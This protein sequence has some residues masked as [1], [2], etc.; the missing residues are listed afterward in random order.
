LKQSGYRGPLWAIIFT[1]TVE[2]IRRC[3][4]CFACEEYLDP[5][6]DLTFGEIFRAAVHDHARALTS[7]TL[8]TCDKLLLNGLHC[9][10]G[11]D[12]EAIIQ[13]LRE[14]ARLRGIDPKISH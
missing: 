14:E 8:W 4:Q 12:L 7:R 11:L 2:D 6:M 9:Q 13:A 10:S 1:A 5:G 3:G